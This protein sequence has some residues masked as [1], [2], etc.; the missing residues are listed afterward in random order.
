MIRLVIAGKHSIVLFL[1]LL[2]ST[3][4]KSQKYNFR[5]VHDDQ[6]FC[7]YDS[8]KLSIPFPSNVTYFKPNVNSKQFKKIASKLS[9]HDLECI[10]SF[11]T[12]KS[13]SLQ[14]KCFLF[15][16]KGDV[17]IGC[18]Q[19]FVNVDNEL[20]ATNKHSL[21]VDSIN[22]R[23]LKIIYLEQDTLLFLSLGNKGDFK[24]FKNICLN[25]ILSGI[26][27]GSEYMNL[28][29]AHPAEVY[30]R[31]IFEPD[32]TLN[33][34]R[35][36]LTLKDRERNYEDKRSKIYYTQILHTALANFTNV[37]KYN[38]AYLNIASNYFP[39]NVISS[40][41]ISNDSIA[42]DYIVNQ[43]KNKRIVMLNEN[44]YLRNGRMMGYILIKR[45]ID[46]GFKYFAFESIWNEKKLKKIHFTTTETGFYSN[47]PMMANLINEAIKSG[48]FVFGYDSDSLERDKYAA[49]NIY[50][51]TFAQDSLAKVF[52]F[53]GFGHI[54]K[55]I[56]KKTLANELKGLT[57][58]DP[59][60]INQTD[61]Q[62]N[63]NNWLSIIDS[64]KV[65]IKYYTVADIY[66]SN[67]LD[68]KKFAEIMMYNCY[69][70]P[71]IKMNL[72]DSFLISIYNSDNFLI[73]KRTI[74][75]YNYYSEFDHNITPFNFL[76]PIGNYMYIVKQGNKNTYSGRLE[77]NTK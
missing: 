71:K 13:D 33:Y 65:N 16:V 27:S 73:D 76:L 36:Y 23:I 35:P 62:Y 32:S 53:A 25:K 44:H 31:C 64:S 54:S 14:F 37:D 40:S 60:C 56:N 7:I 57:G 29:L 41:V 66:L 21:F 5:L 45:L 19:L 39:R 46:L 11:K 28:S 58:Y 69:K 12:E 17:K 22:Y 18:K 3:T 55:Q 26:K 47:E 68:Y 52:I 2:V 34:V 61:F 9:F 51:K 43:C 75:V 63:S 49:Y 8:L 74:P 42:L 10:G 70:I 24:L 50:S 30:R 77:L 4:V 15:L 20:L 6:T 1:V 59:L 72:N 67:K 48:C 38:S